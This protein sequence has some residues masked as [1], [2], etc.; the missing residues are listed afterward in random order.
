MPAMLVQWEI[1]LQGYLTHK[2]PPPPKDPTIV[3]CLGTCGGPRGVGVSYGRGTPVDLCLVLVRTKSSG[4][5]AC[6]P[7]C[8]ERVSWSLPDRVELGEV[9]LILSQIERLRQSE[10]GTIG[11]VHILMGS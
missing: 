4:G 2:N 10:L 5:T 8:R 3:L 6:V 11:D 7:F 1:S 9:N